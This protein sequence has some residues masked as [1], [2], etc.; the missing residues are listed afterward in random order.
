MEKTACFAP[1]TRGE[2]MPPKKNPSTALF[3]ALK[4]KSDKSREQA[5]RELKALNKDLAT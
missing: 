3:K 1:K 2:R 5:L 4:G